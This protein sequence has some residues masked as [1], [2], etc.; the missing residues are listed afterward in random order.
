CTSHAMVLPINGVPN[1]RRV[2]LLM[3]IS[4]LSKTNQVTSCLTV[5]V[6]LVAKNMAWKADMV[7]T[8]PLK[9][10]GN[11]CRSI[12]V[13]VAPHLTVVTSTSARSGVAV[14]VQDALA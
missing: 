2:N 12:A 14:P 6:F 8:M 9:S 7:S 1:V 11:F 10:I 5:G 13:G 4:M 3:T